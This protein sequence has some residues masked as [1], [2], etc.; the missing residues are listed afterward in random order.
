MRWIRSLPLTTERNPAPSDPRCCP[1]QVL[2][3]RR[4]LPEH[5]DWL[6]EKGSP[7]RR[8]LPPPARSSCQWS[9]R[10][11]A[12]THTYTHTHSL[13]HTRHAWKVP[14]RGGGHTGGLWL[15]CAR[16]W[17]E[18]EFAIKASIHTSPQTKCSVQGGKRT[19]A[20]SNASSSPHGGRRT[21]FLI[22]SKLS[23]F[24]CAQGNTA[25]DP[26]LRRAAFLFFLVRRGE[27][28][29][30]ARNDDACLSAFSPG[31]SRTYWLRAEFDSP[32]WGA[33]EAAAHGLTHTEEKCP[34]PLLRCG[35]RPG[36][37]CFS[38]WISRWLKVNA[39]S[40]PVNLEIV[41]SL[42]KRKSCVNSCELQQMGLVLMEETTWAEFSHRRGREIV[43]PSILATGFHKD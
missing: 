37:C 43:F 6:K 16:D 21:R 24:A 11:G 8:L 3:Q 41:H 17:P 22:R 7:Q 38:L 36:F 35:P 39:L 42:Q 34:D 10:S 31:E 32:S 14:Q 28:L 30:A 20:G 15:E 5:L 4:H 19:E 9:A 13:S 23:H 1:G 18:H 12:H 25:L 29:A 2:M 33:A 40:W 26:F 27:Y